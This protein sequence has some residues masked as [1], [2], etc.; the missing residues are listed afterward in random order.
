MARLHYRKDQLVVQPRT[1]SSPRPVR[2][3]TLGLS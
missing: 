1:A 2:L 3:G